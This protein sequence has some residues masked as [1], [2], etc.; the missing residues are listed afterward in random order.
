[1]VPLAGLICEPETE[2]AFRRESLPVVVD[3][4]DQ[5]FT[6]VRP[7][8]LLFSVVVLAARVA[9]GT[10]TAIGVSVQAA[11]RR[12]EDA[13]RELAGLDA[14]LK[15]K[16][17]ELIVKDDELKKKTTQLDERGKE[18]REAQTAV[19]EAEKTLAG[20]QI[21]LSSAQAE[22][23]SAR[24]ET[25]VER[26]RA[27]SARKTADEQQRIAFSR[28]L[29]G[30]AASYQDRQRDLSLLLNAE[31]Y[32]NSPTFEARSGLLRRAAHLPAPHQRPARTQRPRPV[33]RLG[34]DAGS[35][36]PAVW[37]GASSSGTPSGA[38]LSAAASCCQPSLSL[39]RRPAEVPESAPSGSAS[40]ATGGSSSRR[41]SRANTRACGTSRRGASQARWPSTQSASPRTANS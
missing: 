7:P 11:N 12:L 32:R 18:L 37:M 29:A 40:A 26:A 25:S 14:E 24:A 6:L 20:F 13:Q 39:R 27:A 21:E 23:K 10:G 33:V 28:R 16:A 9:L 15:K 3:R 31:A 30:Q 22:V 19:A 8:M 17:D 5:S 4:I 36:S 34:P 1:M 38:R 35:W 2:Q 41:T